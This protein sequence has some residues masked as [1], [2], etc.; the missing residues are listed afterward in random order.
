MEP[1]TMAGL[2]ALDPPYLESVVFPQQKLWYVDICL[3][4][5][6]DEGASR[7]VSGVVV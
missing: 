5:G 3:G 6:E 2:T 7:S 4:A 1:L